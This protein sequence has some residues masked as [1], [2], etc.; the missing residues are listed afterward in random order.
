MALTEYRLGSL[1]VVEN[2]D[3][4]D[5]INRRLR[6]LDPNLFLEK[7]LTFEGEHVWCVVE[8]VDGGDH[9]PVTVYEHRLPDG[10]PYPVP[11]EALI[12]EMRRRA[13]AMTRDPRERR[14][15]LIARA[16]RQNR[17]LREKIAERQRE[18]HAEVNREFRR[19]QRTSSPVH[20]SQQLRMTRDKMRARGEKA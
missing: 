8:Q 19:M 12:E 16:D 13:Q 20:R 7:Q 5:W 1:C 9:P 18:Q 4:R 11:N 2:V 3:D 14:R 17:M 10:R 6:A 15:Q